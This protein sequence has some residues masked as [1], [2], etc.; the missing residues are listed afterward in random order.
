[1]GYPS[2]PELY[3]V[4]PEVNW[5]T[6]WVGH[7]ITTEVIRQFGWQ[8]HLT[9]IPYLIVDHIIHYGDLGAFLVNLKSRSNRRNIIVTTVF[10]G[11]RSEQFPELTQSI[12]LLLEN[13][14]I[15][16]KILTANRI[17]ETRIRSSAYL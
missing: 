3:Y 9:S 7:Y 11:N 8:T 2:L 12:D 16:Q 4:V 15:P 14:H 1:M 17:M 10:H 13:I 6:D 5:V